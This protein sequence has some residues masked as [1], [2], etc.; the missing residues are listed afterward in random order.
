MD[1]FHFAIYPLR[2]AAFNRAR[3]ANKLFEHA[4]VGATSLMS[5]I[6]AL[7]DAAGSA[8]TGLFVEGGPDEWRARIEV[9]L[10]DLAAARARAERVGKHI[11]EI[12][13]LGAAAE[14]WLAILSGDT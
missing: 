7:V 5:P 6:P 14:R 1:G 2:D 10:A 3:S 8:S 12:D 4:L 11:S 9:D 13:P